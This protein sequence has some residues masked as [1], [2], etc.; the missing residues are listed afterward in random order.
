M[1]HMLLK[2]FSILNDGFTVETHNFPY[3][4]VIGGI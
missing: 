1:Q 4:P 2:I 3:P